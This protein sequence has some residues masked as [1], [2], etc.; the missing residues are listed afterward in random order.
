M[1]YEM[2][3]EKF[4]LI[5]ILFL[6]FIFNYSWLDSFL[7]EKF[8]Y[9]TRTG[10]IE[11]VIDGDTIVIDGTKIRL[12]GINSPEKKEIGFEEAKSFLEKFNGSKVLIENENEKYDLYGRELAYLF[13]NGENINQKMVEEGFANIYF[14]NGKTKYYSSFLSAWENCMENQKGICKNIEENCLEINWKPKEDLVQ[15]ENICDYSFELTNYSIKDEG[16]KKFIFN[17]KQL[18]KGEIIIL[19]SLNFSEKYVWTKSGDSIFVRDEKNTLI[20]FDHY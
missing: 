8:S 6:L 12:L 11:R 19:N 13:F 7:I 14:P 16:R 10:I 17:K 9:Q 2:E 5:F 3:K 1:I 20:Y 15:L 4:I 18:E